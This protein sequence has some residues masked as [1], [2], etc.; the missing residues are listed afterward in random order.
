[1][2]FAARC[3]KARRQ[4]GLSQRALASLI[5]VGRSAVSNWEAPGRGTLP[6]CRNLRAF[7]KSTNVSFNWLA[8]GVG[9]MRPDHD[10]L[11]D[12]PAVDADLV[13]ERHERRMLRVFRSVPRATQR[14]MLLV[15]E[16]LAATQAN[17]GATRSR[18]AGALLQST[19]HRLGASVQVNSARS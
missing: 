17:K 4:A 13:Y 1:M 19:A 18:P 11:L 14:V 16:E 6:C 15:V 10:P 3:R 2:N 8:M 9:E 12:V 7:A 5:G